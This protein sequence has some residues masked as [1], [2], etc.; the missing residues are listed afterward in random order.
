MASTFLFEAEGAALTVLG[1]VAGKGLG[2]GRQEQRRQEQDRAGEPVEADAFVIT[3][4]T[5]LTSD[6]TP[7][8]TH[9]FSA[10]ESVGKKLIAFG[11]A[12]CFR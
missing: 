1:A 3:V 2:R 7:D 4:P 6:R 11:G 10:T 8:M 12:Q 9:V 5:P